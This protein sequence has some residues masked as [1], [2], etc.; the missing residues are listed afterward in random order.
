MKKLFIALLISVTTLAFTITPAN[1]NT[2]VN[3][4]NSTKVE[5]ENLHI[6]EYDGETYTVEVNE[7]DGIR[8]VTI[9]EEVVSYNT[10]TGEMVVNG[11]V[12]EEGKPSFHTQ[13]LL[14][15]VSSRPG[16]ISTQAVVP[17]D[18][19]DTSAWKLEVNQT[20]SLNG[21]AATA[22]TIVAI[23]VSR[24]PKAGKATTAMWAFGTALVGSTMIDSM[25]VYFRIKIYSNT[26][27]GLKF[28]YYMY[29]YKNSNYTGYKGSKSFSYTAH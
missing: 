5:G 22:G 21:F 13:N 27:N 8:T 19:A 23:L 7:M 18:G 14:P 10:A 17:I 29:F 4:Q 28:K 15:G 25:N 2:T 11:E 1:A 6:V 12:M 20:G 26:S 24:N 9:N 3:S 16:G